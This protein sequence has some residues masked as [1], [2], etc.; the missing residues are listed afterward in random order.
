MTRSISPVREIPILSRKILALY[1]ENWVV[2]D[3]FFFLISR[4]TGYFVQHFGYYLLEVEK[5]RKF[6]D[7]VEKLEKTKSFFSSAENCKV[8]VGIFVSPLLSPQKCSSRRSCSQCHNF[9]IS[10]W[11]F[12]AI[13]ASWGL[14]FLCDASIYSSFHLTRPR[15]RTT[16]FKYSRYWSNGSRA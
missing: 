3:L 1:R 15:S 10:T 6:W 11:I 4:V 16:I 5:V 14:T 9:P 2:N 13:L 8:L 7:S 12:E